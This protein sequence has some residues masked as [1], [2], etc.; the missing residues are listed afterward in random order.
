MRVTTPAT[1]AV[2]QTG[3]AHPRWGL[4]APALA[5]LGLVAVAA[6]ACA[7]AS[8]GERPA[9]KP[10]DIGLL[11]AAT[12]DGG[13]MEAVEGTSRF[14]LTLN[15][16]TPQVVWFSDRPAR[17]SG[18]IPVGELVES[19]EGYGFVE[20]PP[21]AAL[22]VVGADDSQDTVVVELGSPELDEQQNT[23]RFA[24]EVLDEATGNLSHLA[25]D[26]DQSV[27]GTFGPATLFID[28]TTGVVINKCPIHTNTNCPGADLHGAWLVGFWLTGSDLSKANLSGANLRGTNLNNTNLSGADLTNADTTGAAEERQP[29]QRQPDECELDLGRPDR[30]RHDQCRHD[31]GHVL[32]QDA[33]R[34]LERQQLL[35]SP[36][37]HD[38]R[39]NCRQRRPALDAIGYVKSPGRLPNRSLPGLLAA[40]DGGTRTATLMS[41][42]SQP[43]WSSP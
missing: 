9:Q 19:W 33:E 43:P 29:E 14:E 2:M 17:Q 20:D 10:Q 3:V 23:V 5:V 22:A 13:T 11:F 35:T 42:P 15:K 24:A 8:A 32:D 4:R 37:R 30:S 34:T 41:D 18:H 7:P 12:A 36:R 21:N 28:N 38:G 26:L 25:S 16:V 27:E 6:T 31:R 40:A 39:V 1:D